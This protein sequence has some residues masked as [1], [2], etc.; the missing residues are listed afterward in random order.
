MKEI[1]VVIATKNRPELLATAIQSVITQKRQANEVILVSQSN[2]DNQHIE[3]QL[4]QQHQFIFLQ[5]KNTDNYAGN[6]NTAIEYIIKNRLLIQNK[7]ID[8]TFI[9]FLDDDDWWEKDYLFCCQKAILPNTD[10]VVTGLNYHSNNENKALSIPQTLNIQDFLKGNPHIQGSNTFVRFSTL[11]K[12][13]CFDENMP[14]TTDRDIFTRIMMLNPTY[15]IINQHLVHINADNHR[16]RLTNIAPQKQESLA[17]FYAKYGGLMDKKTEQAFFQRTERFLG[18]A[19]NKQDIQNQFSTPNQSLFNTE[20][21]TQNTLQ[22]CVIFAFISINAFFTQRLIQEIQKQT[23]I[24]NKKIICLCNYF[25]DI[26]LVK[27]LLKSSQIPFILIELSDIQILLKQQY[28]NHHINH[29]FE[30]NPHQTIKDIAMARTLLHFYSKQY[31][32]DGDII[33]ILDDDMQ[34][35]QLTLQNQTM[36]RIPLSVSDYILRYKNEYDVVIGSYNGDAPSPTLLTLRTSLLDFVYA[37]KL[38]KNEFFDKNIYELRDYHYDLASHHQHLETP[39]K[40]NENATLDEIFSGKASSRPLWT[41]EIKTFAPYS[42]GGNTLIFNRQVL[43]IPNFSIVFNQKMTRRGDFFWVLQAQEQGYKITASSIATYHNRQLTHFDYDKEVDKAIDDL[44]GASFIWAYQQL[45]N[46]QD[47]QAF[48]RLFAEFYQNRLTLIIL[49]YYRIIGLLT[50]LDKADEYQYFNIDNLNYLIKQCKQNLLF[51]KVYVAFK[52]LH[53]S[54]SQQKQLLKLADYRQMIQDAFVLTQPLELLGL[55]D[56]GMVFTDKNRVYKLFYQALPQES[57]ELYE[58]HGDM[59]AQSRH[60]SPVRIQKIRG[61]DVLDYPYVAFEPYQGRFAEQVV[62]L[63]LFL[64]QNN[65]VLSNIKKGNFIVGNGILKW[66]DFGKN[67]EQYSKEKYQKSIE[68]AYQMLKFAFLDE[69]QFKEMV[70]STYQNKGKHFNFGIEHFKQLFLQ[71]TKEDIHDSHIIDLIKQFNPVTYLDY[72]AGKCKIA[73][74]LSHK[75]QTSVFDV[76][77]ETIVKRANANIQIIDD[78]EHCQKS[79][80]LIN[81]NLVLCCIS[82]HHIQHAIQNMYR[83]LD[84]KGHLIIS[85]CNP[86]FE[87]IQQTELKYSGYTGDYQKCDC[88]HK[89]T[90]YGNRLEYHRPFAFYER[91]LAKNGFEITAIQETDGIN[92]QS[93]NPIAEHLIFVCQKITKPVLNDCSLLIKT[94]PMEHFNIEKNIKHI[95]TQLEKDSV[96]AERIVVVDCDKNERA[97]RYADDNRAS[98]TLALQSLQENG[99]ID[100]V[101]FVDEWQDKGVYQKYFAIEN[102][103]SHSQNGQAILASLVGLEAIQTRYVFQTD[104]DILYFNESRLGFQAALNQLKQQQALTLS[105]S[106][107]HSKAQNITFGHRTEVRACFLDLQKL[108]ALLPLENALNNNTLIHTWHK[109]LD[110]KLNANQ[111]I[112]LYQDDLFFIHPENHLKQDNLI[113]VVREQLEQG[114]THFF[115]IQNNQVNLQGT[116]ADW[117][118]KTHQAMV[119]FIRGKNTPPEKLN[120]LFLS[121][122]QQSHQNFMM[123]YVDDAS[124][125]LSSEYAKMQFDYCPYFKNKVIA[126]FNDKSVG[127]LANFELMYRHIVQNHQAIIVNIDNDDC[128]LDNNALSVIQ[129]AFDKGVDVTVGNCFRVDKPLTEYQVTDF[130]QSWHRGGDN[131][132]LHPKCFRKYLC[133]YVQ[134]NLK[135]EQGNY[136]TVAT[137]YAMMLPIVEH[138]KSPVFIDKKLY[139]FEPSMANQH[140]TGVYQK[141]QTNRQLLLKKAEQ[142]SNKKIIAIIG[143]GHLAENSPAYLLAYELGKTLVDKGYRIQNGG[144][145]GVMEASMK[146]AKASKHY[147]KG[148]TIAI[149][150]SSDVRQVNAYADVVIPTGLDILRN[151]KVIEAD[152]VI[153]IGGGAGTLSE[154]AMAWQVF[155]FIIAFENIDGWSQKLANQKLDNKVRYPN[156]PDDRIYGVQNI[157]EAIDLI[158]QKINQYHR[159]HHGIV[160]YPSNKGK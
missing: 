156:M 151:G 158:E 140:K 110:N 24:P 75:I 78:I 17:K 147:Q 7:K 71:R 96:F 38:N 87:N 72:G 59:L 138:A 69:M 136:I 14:S 103:Q 46:K 129:A 2:L 94:N 84:D 67:I 73:N 22:E 117:L 77:K 148:D 15:T 111:S 124:E 134:D 79:F 98:L 152:A 121:L 68:R 47:S 55:G 61:F 27:E 157:E 142:L 70:A 108:N 5:N 122:K 35:E 20:N 6:L 21:I 43:D 91:L 56:E 155:K 90:P 16:P 113:S 141:A 63:I 33:W 23:N 39:V 57:Y 34:F 81:C 92:M 44:I 88:Y 132:W 95:I 62:D 106:I 135:D 89:H 130:Y 8:N 86:F 150:P 49:N 58:R 131:I 145:G 40:I 36:C 149:I 65:L 9:A 105:L 3:K 12:A 26:D 37:K 30:N 97:R 41:S 137:D 133:H 125:T 127:S 104:S 85:I 53:S 93:L 143:D 80:E 146:G 102:A 101:I 31:S 83:S 19:L 107:C 120:R 119:L 66:V 109:A 60:L 154:M 112:R 32:K 13:G 128:L 82:E 126:L 114:N 10:F 29:Y 25:D 11:L 48:Y 28:F 64:R 160:F 54:L 50:I 45:E 139:Y 153:A 100:K 115:A 42:R 116:I 123:I 4:C 76:D 52:A 51:E 18:K 144:L 1:I 118:P 74:Q 99:L 159:V